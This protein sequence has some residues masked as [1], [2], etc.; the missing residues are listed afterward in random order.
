M[1]TD[2]PSSAR[3]WAPVLLTALCI[4][5]TVSRSAIVAVACAFGVFMVLMP[6]RQRMTAFILVP[7]AIGSVF[8]T[9][10]GQIGTLVNLFGAGNGD[11]SI[12]HRTNNYPFVDH[13]VSQA[14]WLGTGGGT[15]IPYGTHVLDNQYLTTAI[16]LGLIG[17]G[18]LICLFLFPM[19]IALRSRTMSND[20]S[21]RL[22]CA[23]LAGVALAGGITSAFFDSFSFP[24]FYNVFAIGLGIIG[25]CWRLAKRESV[26]RRIRKSGPI[27]Q[28][29]Y[30]TS[31]TRSF[32][33]L[34]GD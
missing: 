33:T 27:P 22:L 2:V 20:P 5:A 18:V 8:V 24:L 19:L 12:A 23:A 16:E 7:V 4:P 28:L 9:S 21:L 15:Y 26:G 32:V 29:A 17:V 30:A 6:L 25:A 13:L 10:H 1:H 34:N 31:A 14:P 3:R 11:S